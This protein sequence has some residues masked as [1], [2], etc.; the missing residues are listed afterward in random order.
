MQLISQ[1]TSHSRLTIPILCLMPTIGMASLMYAQVPV[2]DPSN[3]SVLQGAIKSLDAT[4]QVLKSS[5]QETDCLDE[6]VVHSVQEINNTVMAISNEIPK[7]Q[8][9]L[10]SALGQ[11]NKDH[12]IN[13][14][15]SCVDSIQDKANTPEIAASLDSLKDKLATVEQPITN[16]LN[17]MAEE[18]YLIDDENE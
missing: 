7:E 4:V 12:I 10:D 14:A 16:T 15:Q 1:V 2:I 5:N 18:Q 13:K 17:A 3:S 6:L 8:L 11:E 9:K